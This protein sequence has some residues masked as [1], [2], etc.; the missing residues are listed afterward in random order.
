MFGRFQHVFIIAVMNS[1]THS[2]I[3]FMLIHFAQ[4]YLTN[5]RSLFLHKAEK[6]LLNV[7]IRLIKSVL[8][9]MHINLCK[10][11]LFIT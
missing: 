4:A 2:E 5:Q 1:Y 9:E 10:W 7:N 3:I 11:L 8:F 6:I